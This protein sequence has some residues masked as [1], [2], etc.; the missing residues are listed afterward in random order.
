MSAGTP[1]TAT[2]S[3]TA[4]SGG[5]K[6]SFVHLHVHTEYSML[7]GAARLG[8]LTQR[9]ADL[10]MPAVAM[11]DHGNVFGAY[12]F[13]AK[14]KAAGIKPIIGIEAYFTPNIS[15]FEKKG[16]NFYDGGPDDVS[17]RG[18]YTHM[19]LLSESTEG[20]HNLFRL[21][22]GSWRDGFFKHP[23]MDRELLAQHS[24]GIIGTTGCPSG[25]VQVHLRYGNYDAAR[26][27][28]GDFQDILGKENYFLELMDHGLDI[29]R[30]V[31]DGLLRLAE[32]LRIPLLATNDSH[33]V[34]REDAASQQQGNDAED[35]E[36]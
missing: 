28:A 17:A 1:E 22:T 20:M 12:E 2:T 30:R 14:A 11:T 35:K 9:A 16:V 27:A 36:L 34:N 7:D 21:S 29:E 19:T 32:D 8:D 33:Y 24:K 13:Y 26:K 4:G 10:G 5:S 3:T 23:R 15:R 18:A 6:D 25:E 31:R